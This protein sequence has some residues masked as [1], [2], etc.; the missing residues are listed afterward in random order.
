MIH[1]N[2]V[3]ISRPFLLIFAAV[4]V[5]KGLDHL[6][7]DHFVVFSPHG[8]HWNILQ[9]VGSILVLARRRTVGSFRIGQSPVQTTNFI[10]QTNFLGLSTRPDFALRQGLDRG[11]VQLSAVAHHRFEI[12]V[13]TINRLGHTVLHGPAHGGQRIK[14]P[15]QGP[16]RH[17]IRGNPILVGQTRQVGT[18][19]KDPN[20]SRQRLVGGK[21]AI[22]VGRNVV[23]PAGRDIAHGDHHGHGE[24]LQFLGNGFA[25]NGVAARAGDSQDDAFDVVLVVI[26]VVVSWGRG[27]SQLG[28]EL[29]GQSFVNGTRNVCE[30]DGFLLVLLFAVKSCRGVSGGK[31]G[32]PKGQVVGLPKSLP[33]GPLGLQSSQLALLPGIVG[34]RHRLGMVGKA[35]KI[36][37]LGLPLV[38]NGVAFT[39]RNR[40]FRFVWTSRFFCF[41]VLGGIVRAIAVGQQCRQGIATGRVIHQTG[42]HCRRGRKGT[43][44]VNLVPNVHHLVAP[45]VKRAAQQGRETLVGRGVVIILGVILHFVLV[46]QEPRSQQGLGPRSG[47]VECQVGLEL[48]DHVLNGF[49]VGRRQFGFRQDVG[50]RFVGPVSKDVQSNVPLILQETPEKQVLRVQAQQSHLTPLLQ[51]HVGTRRGQVIIDRGRRH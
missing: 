26:V 17:G 27:L 3:G 24:G 30:Q 4:G 20:R 49:A 33:P 18:N 51:V 7:K 48:F 29:A 10:H 23:P 34:Q 44:S 8:D 32:R 13:D 39:R 38:S 5:D 45:F 11:L 25:G 6:S 14:G 16:R 22:G 2:R 46:G 9:I 40:R 1:R 15:R 36:R 43:R 37:F 31:H 21:N 42:A 35:V 12:I 47:H 28:H 19:G 50:R 41:L